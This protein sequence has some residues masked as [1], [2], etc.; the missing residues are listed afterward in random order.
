M[1]WPAEFH[2]YRTRTSWLFRPLFDWLLLPSLQWQTVNLDTRQSTFNKTGSILVWF[3][4]IWKCIFE[5]FQGLITIFAL[6]NGLNASISFIIGCDSVSESSAPRAAAFLTICL[7][8]GLTLGAC[9][10]FLVILVVW[11]RPE[12]RPLYRNQW[13]S[14][15]HSN[16]HPIQQDF[17]FNTRSQ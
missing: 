1:S 13:Y 2:L 15:F 12:I 9:F 17:I 4:Q 7:T 6:G 14:L 10:S 5:H 11:R 3:F 16:K 8:A